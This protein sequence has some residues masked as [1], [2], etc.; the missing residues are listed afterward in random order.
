MQTRRYPEKDGRRVWLSRGEQD[1]LLDVFD[2]DPEKQLAVRL[3]LCGLRADEVVAGEGR[4]G[5]CREHIRALDSDREAWKLEVPVSKRAARETPLPGET[6]RLLNTTANVRGL[7]KDEPVID[8]GKRSIQRW[9]SNAAA[10]L[11][12]E[13]PAKRWDDVTFHDLRRSWATDTYYSLSFAGVSIAETLVMGWGGW[14]MTE[15][16]RRTFRE[17]YLGPEPDHIAAEAIHTAGLE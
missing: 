15:S 11:A 8:A 1:R 10:D 13:E 16:G 9:V 17:N 5:V 3:G 4:P 7:R 12:E 2:E 6:K 14:A